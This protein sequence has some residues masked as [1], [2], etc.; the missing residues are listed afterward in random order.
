MSRIRLFLPLVFC[1]CGCSYVGA[2]WTWNPARAA[3]DADHDIAAG[4]IQ[5]V[6]IGGLASHAPGLPSGSYDVI[7]R[8]PR[9]MIGPQ[10]CNQDNGS[11]VRA[12]YAWK[13]NARMWAYVSSHPHHLTK[14]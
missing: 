10:G 4:K 3:S 7:S 2:L 13:Y 11:G 5:F 12:N 6:Y 1:L 9:L 14:R 8:Y